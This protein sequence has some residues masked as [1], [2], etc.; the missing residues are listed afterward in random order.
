MDLRWILLLLVLPLALG[1]EETWSG[2]SEVRFKGYSTLHNFEGTVGPVP[3]KVTVA[4]GQSGR[5]VSATSK[6]PVKKMTTNHEG[7]DRNMMAMFNE[8]FFHVID[9]E[10]VD[11]PETEL[12][13]QDG[14]P[15]T[16]RI[17]LTIAGQR[18]LGR[19]VVTNLNEAENNLSFDLSFPLSLKAFKLQPP[20]ALGGLVKVK[21]TVDVTAHVVLTK[22]SAP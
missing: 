7:R 21:D 14:K 15:G 13:P 19:A 22:R 11:A 2:T 5:I 8:R 9:V 10:V 17:A 4:P 20:G 1:A 16:M 18:A 12:R 3:L 6:V